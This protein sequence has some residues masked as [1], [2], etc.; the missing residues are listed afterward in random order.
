ML[1]RKAE[2][3]PGQVSL[4]VVLSNPHLPGNSFSLS[5][6]LLLR[7][8]R[9]IYV[10]TILN[11]ESETLVVSAVVFPVCGREDSFPG[12]HSLPIDFKSS[13]PKKL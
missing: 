6:H 5:A 1:I 10:V 13:G 12:F 9:F 4:M 2:L 7:D 11:V 8:G 3:G